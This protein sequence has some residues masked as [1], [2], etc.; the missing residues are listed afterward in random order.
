MV[1]APRLAATRH[2]MSRTSSPE[3]G[4]SIGSSFDAMALI[5]RGDTCARADD[6]STG[7]RAP[8]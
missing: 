6:F 1:A 3:R 4:F 5:E 8:T 7:Q 2:A